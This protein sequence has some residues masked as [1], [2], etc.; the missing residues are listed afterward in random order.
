MNAMHGNRA[1]R[2]G[3]D[4]Q[5]SWG[6][7][8]WSLH[9][10]AGS[11]HCCPVG[12]MP[13]ERLFL[14]VFP[15]MGSAGGGLPGDSTAKMKWRAMSF[16]CTLMD[17]PPHPHLHSLGTSSCSHSPQR[18]ALWA[19]KEKK[20]EKITPKQPQNEEEWGRE[21]AKPHLPGCFQRKEQSVQGEGT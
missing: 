17:S 20:K 18:K 13:W 12:K 21:Q 1:T 4:E 5:L 19:K 6:W 10:L 15:V 2:K 8:Q 3:W 11:N 14:P 16:I 7:S 9:H